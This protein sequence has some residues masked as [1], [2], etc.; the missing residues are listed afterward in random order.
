MTKCPNCG[1]FLDKN[2]NCLI[3]GYSANAVSDIKKLLNEKRYTEALNKCKEID[4]DA[5]AN[6]LYVRAATKDFSEKPVDIAEVK[7]HA[8]YGLTHA[9][10]EE[11]N[12]VEYKLT[13]YFNNLNNGGNGVVTV[14]DVTA[15]EALI[16]KP[17]PTQ[18]AY[19]DTSTP[20]T[21]T[22]APHVKKARKPLS[23]G[24][25][26]GIYAG[27][28]AVVCA[29]LIPVIVKSG[30]KETVVSL[31]K[32]GGTGGS[33][34]IY[35][36]YKKEVPTINSLPERTGYTFEGYFDS[37]RDGSGTRYFDAYGNYMNGKKWMIKDSY[38]YLYAHW[39]EEYSTSNT[40][41]ITFDAYDYSHGC[42]FDLS[43]NGCTSSTY[44]YYG[45]Y[46]N[47][48]TVPYENNCGYRFYGY[49]DQKNGTGT[50]Y[51]DSYGDPCN[52]WNKQVSACTLYAYW[53]Y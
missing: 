34:Y 38:F 45:N 33:S 12:Q 46:P 42:S 13:H 17:E 18:T 37:K 53:V 24:V 23:K 25:R 39:K 10:Q 52:A 21:H 4:T 14:F 43:F 47:S 51:F 44:A 49:Y 31:N 27:V 41:L 8:V 50:R 19:G 22:S 26:V 15:A 32:N 29:V 16:H 48:I 1:A 35:L 28:F 5:T 6:L 36:K 20:E 2:G 30:K 3:C 40:T 11:I 7:R 9:T